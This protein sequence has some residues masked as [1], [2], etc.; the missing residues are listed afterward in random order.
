MSRRMIPLLLWLA[1]GAA[2]PAQEAA[3]AHPRPSEEALDRLADLE[4]EIDEHVMAWR[5]G[6]AERREKHLEEARKAAEEGRPIPAL[7][8]RPDFS[9][10]VDRLIAWADA[11]GGEDAALYLTKVVELNGFG[12]GSKG[13]AAFDRL[14]V[15][16][17]ASPCWTR[18]GRYLPMLDRILDEAHEAAVL[19][20]LA[21]SPDADVRGWVTMG[22]HSAAIEEA[23]RDSKEYAEARAAILAA[24]Q[25]VSDAEL[26]FELEGLIALREEYGVGA[27]APDIEGID[28]D[29]VGFKLSDYRGKVVFLDFWGDW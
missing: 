4:E 9:E 3:Q 26:R 21:K 27:T 19:A 14:V 13:R 15:D 11:S 18:L 17:A 7:P 22:L 8:M 24:A 6:Q 2:A 10:L 29:G 12:E 20:V 25:R 23:P 1:C 16:H 28:L 5:E